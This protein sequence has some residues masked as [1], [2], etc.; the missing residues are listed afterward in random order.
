MEILIKEIETSLNVAE[1]YAHFNSR[2][3]IMLDSSKEDKELEE[4]YNK[5]VVITHHLPTYSLICDKYFDHPMNS[6]FATN[7]HNLIKQADIWCC[8]HSHHVEYSKIGKCRCYLNPIGYFN[9]DSQYIY[10]KNVVL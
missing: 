5:T 4:E 1:I 7:L 6:F 8:G 9:E 2:N 3:N 10:P